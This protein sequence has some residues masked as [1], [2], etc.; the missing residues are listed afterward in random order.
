ME[1]DE[2]NYYFSIVGD[3]ELQS[4]VVEKIFNDLGVFDTKTINEN[5]KKSFINF[6]SYCVDQQTYQKLS[7]KDISELMS[8]LTNNITVSANWS[9]V[10]PKYINDELA[11]TYFRF[12]KEEDKERYLAY[13]ILGKNYHDLKD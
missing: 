7:D 4:D 10:P 5:N 3:I 13:Y 8:N 6:I 1:K 12:K 11:I 9:I 2:L